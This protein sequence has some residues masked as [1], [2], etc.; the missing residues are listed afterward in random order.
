MISVRAR[1]HRK[2][3]LAKIVVFAFYASVQ[4]AANRV[5][6]A[7]IAN[8]EMGKTASLLNLSIHGIQNT[9]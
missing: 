9:G 4:Y 8:T 1:R 3:L 2:T 5:N 7:M 6:R